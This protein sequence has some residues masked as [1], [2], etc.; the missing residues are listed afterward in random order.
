MYY[1]REA[2]KG[3]LYTQQAILLIL[4]PIIMVVGLY[5][6]ADALN[7]GAIE[8][9]PVHTQAQVLA[10][11]DH[12]FNATSYEIFYLFTTEDSSQWI[13]KYQV[14]DVNR[15]YPKPAAGDE[16]ALAYSGSA[17]EYNIPANMH[18]FTKTAFAIFVSSLLAFVFTFG[19]IVYLIIKIEKHKQQDK[20]Y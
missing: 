10:I 13:G 12:S 20:Y 16:L 11:R 3:N 18:P 19:A 14:N 1:P 17:P 8:I 6:K 2:Q 15:E 7:Y 4:L 9:N 5:A